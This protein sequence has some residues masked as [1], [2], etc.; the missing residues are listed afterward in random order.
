[1]A[2]EKILKIVLIILGAAMISAT[3]Y[4]VWKINKNIEKITSKPPELVIPKKLETK[5]IDTSDWKTYRNEKYGFEVKYPKEWKVTEIPEF[6][7]LLEGEYSEERWPTV[8]ISSP[9][10]ES[11][12]P[13]EE[14]D[15]VEWVKKEFGDIEERGY[16]RIPI[17][18]NI[19]VD[20][21]LGVKI[22]N[23]PPPTIEARCIDIIFIKKRNKLFEIH[24]NDSDKKELEN[25]YNQILSTLKFL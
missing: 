21:T 4:A 13:P 6:G 19:E 1:M 14:V 11:Y 17:A 24:L 2:K 20:R 8:Q 18:P 9:D 7:A 16:G 23:C 25:L 12:R 15:I 3:G 5:E 10:M 22:Q